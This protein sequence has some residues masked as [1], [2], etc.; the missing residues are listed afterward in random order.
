MAEDKA[1]LN[2]SLWK[3]LE[4]SPMP[5]SFVEHFLEWFDMTPRHSNGCGKTQ[6]YL[7]PIYP[8]GKLFANPPK[9][10]VL[11]SGTQIRGKGTIIYR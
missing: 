6:S 10:W 11:A 4:R 7:H 9:K 8:Q 5:G 3:S 1:W 2:L